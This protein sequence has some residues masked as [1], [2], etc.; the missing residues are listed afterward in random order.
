[1]NENETNEIIKEIR[2]YQT[3]IKTHRS[4]IETCKRKVNKLYTE[5][6][7]MGLQAYI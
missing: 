2:K 7:T 5:L 1:M 6:K 4:S 3:F